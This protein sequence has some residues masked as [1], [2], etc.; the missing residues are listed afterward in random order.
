MRKILDAD[1]LTD[2]PIIAAIKDETGLAE[3]LRT[4]CHVIFILFGNVCNIGEIVAKVKDAGKLAIV[5]MDLVT[6]LSSKEISVD[7]IQKS[8]RADGIISTKPMIIKR[9]KELGIPAVQRFFIIDSIALENSKRQ[10]ELYH[11]DCVE[12]MPGIMPKILKDIRNFVDVPIIAG[13]LL[14]D[15]KDVMGAL[16][17]GA[18]AISTTNRK[19]W[20]I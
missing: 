4:E 13:G 20:S 8:T 6:G 15:K 17:A 1:T 11:P 10:I 14:T 19:L 5:H 12:I 3:C 7:F 9:A 18:D 16:S 2:S